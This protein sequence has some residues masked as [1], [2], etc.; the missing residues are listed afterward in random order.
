M[1]HLI[2]S[3]LVITLPP[4]GDVYA[5][6]LD[7]VVYP[8]QWMSIAVAVGLLVLRKREPYINRPFRAWNIAP[9]IQI[10]SSLGLL[11]SP[12]M[13]GEDGKGDVSFW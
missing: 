11:A 10:L 4:P 5:F 6:I 9:F 8:A 7:C 12:F 13:H 2:P 3:I 1:L